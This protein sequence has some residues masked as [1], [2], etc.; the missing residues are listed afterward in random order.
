MHIKN[1]TNFWVNVTIGG[2]MGIGNIQGLERWLGIKVFRPRSSSVI[3]AVNKNH[4][5]SLHRTIEF[6]QRAPGDFLLRAKKEHVIGSNNTEL[7]R[8]LI[9]FKDDGLV[10]TS[11]LIKL[12]VSQIN[13]PTVSPRNT[14]TNQCSLIFP[15]LFFY[16]RQR[17]R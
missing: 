12:N 1:A 17:T 7:P 9:E 6:G 14:Q 2:T 5:K 11:V 13:I 15:L 4:P 8:Y 10:L 3:C 16:C